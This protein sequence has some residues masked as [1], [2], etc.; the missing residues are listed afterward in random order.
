MTDLRAMLERLL[1]ASGSDFD[2]IAFILLER[3]SPSD[4]AVA[5]LAF[6]DDQ[7]APH[8]FVK[9][10][11]DAAGARRL[12]REFRNLSWLHRHGSAELRRAVPAP[13][14]LG[15]LDGVTMLAESAVT[16]TRMK[17]FP[18]DVYF[19]STAFRQ[20][21]AAVVRWLVE[22]HRSA[23]GAS[24]D[25]LPARV[26]ALESVARYREHYQVTAI[27]DELL[28]RCARR[29]EGYTGAVPPWH[30]DFCTANVVIGD[31][32]A[33]AVIDWEYPLVRSWPLADL[34]YFITSTWCVP[35]ARGRRALAANYLRL[36][37]AEHPWREQ[38]REATLSYVR[39]LGIAAELILPL[40]VMAW[41][42]QANRKH[43]E[44]E[45]LR[46]LRDMEV[47][48]TELPLLMVE[49]RHCLNLELLAEHRERFALL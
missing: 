3:S 40:A 26:D 29:L 22:L 48:S 49:E 35:Y 33:I 23:E 38:L 43:E 34:L 9:S 37:F 12:E 30:G 8:A 28:E 5:L 19:A 1:R 39:E 46:D 7:P 44:L 10:S 2:R 32:G 18:P 27:L 16:G 47:E 41:V 45:A 20:H 14:H 6:L 25:P 24:D 17:D 15:Q 4:T 31:G 11:P 21:F 42:A 36:F 13:L